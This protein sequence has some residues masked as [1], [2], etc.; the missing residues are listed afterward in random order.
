M[1]IENILSP[2]DVK[3]LSLEQLNVLADEMHQALIKRAA[4]HYG[5]CG[6]NFGLV[7]AT[8]A[9]HYVFNSPEDKMVFDVSHQ[10]YPHKMLT[11]RAEA[12][13]NPDKYDSVSG[14]SEP[15]ESA[16]DHFVI[17]HTSTSVSLATGLAKGRDLMGG[18]ENVIAIIGDGS[19]SGGEA[20]EGL[21]V[22]G[23]LGTN[24]I[25]IAN[26]NQ[27]SIAENHGGLYTSLAELRE[28]NGTSPNNYFRSLGLDYIYVREGNNIGALIEAFQKVKDI[29]HPIVV[30][31][32]T[33]KGKGYKPA[34][35][36]QETWHWHLPFNI[37][38]GETLP[39]YVS[40]AENY[41][42]LTARHLLSLMPKDPSLVVLT[43]G[44]PTVGG[45]TEDR[46]KQA[47]KQFVDCGIAEE[48]AVAMCSGLAKRGA[49]PVLPIYSTFIQ[50]TYDQLQQDL[51]INNNPATLLV[52]WGSISAMNDVTHT[53][54]YDIPVVANIPNMVYLAPTTYEEYIAMLNWSIQQTAHPV[55]I[56]VPVGPVVHTT[57]AVDTDYS[58]LN[59][60]K[61]EEEGSKVAIIGLGNQL[62]TAKEAARI[63]RE[64]H[65]ITPTV[66]NPRYI[67]GLD[68]DLL[69]SLKA[70][71]SLVITIE[72]GLIDG[73]FGEKIARHYAS[74]ADMKVI[75]R[76]ATKQFQDRY[77]PADLLQ[78]YRMT[79]E[80]IAAD[81]A[82]NA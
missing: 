10:T 44:T 29:D 24:F 63:L 33:L 62:A 72:D 47:G 6:P 38:T 73:G 21:N 13:I 40:D 8:I 54:W 5:H 48:Q 15:D 11:G 43:A 57:K 34:E 46:R 71:H 18:H 64:K 28:T 76:G 78:Q 55:S 53:C 66:I 9:L 19:L 81:A 75:V 79:A 7:E 74:T 12:Y 35:E 2:A 52:F 36:H 32:N 3:K 58:D 25:V 67:T 23:E 1:Y 80:Q 49:H 31:I 77:N 37:E 68:T 20:F 65:G 61:I 27:M 14:Y 45:F 30:H 41:G 60:Y 39:E 51:C 17:G 42:D 26:D 69:D 56:R 4:S 22:A 82:E 70:T 50:R 16:H 59:K